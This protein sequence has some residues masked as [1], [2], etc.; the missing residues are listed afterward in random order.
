MLTPLDILTHLQTYLPALTTL[1]SDS[2]S[3]ATATVA[4][5]VVTV[6]TPSAHGLSPGTKVAFAAGQFQN[7]VTATFL[8]PDDTVRFT[9]GSDHDLTQPKFFDDPDELVLSGVGAPWDGTHKIVAVP[10]RRTFEVALPTGETTA[11]APA[12]LLVEDRPAGIT[13]L[14]TVATVPTS[15]TFT[16]DLSGVPDPPAGT[17][18]SIS[19]VTQIRVA[20]AEDAERA[21]QIYARSSASDANARPWLFLM[22]TGTDASKDRETFSDAIAGFTV[23]D[24]RKQTLLQNF[25]TI[26]ILPTADD[27]TGFTAMS[28]AHSEIFRALASAL[29]SFR[30]EDPDTSIRYVTVS[31]GHGPGTYD[32]SRYT[33]VYDWQ[34]PTVVTYANGFDRQADV[35]FR[36]I[37]Q[38]LGLNSDE[39]AQLVANIDLDDEPLP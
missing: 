33:H 39:A 3:G 26:A 16:V 20:G 35:A 11:P 34:V 24:L 30:F 7:P 36:D 15:T 9:V 17:V 31:N 37:T 8:N 10:N 5:N 4:G 25:A 19:V 14:Q 1:F 23:Q 38:T 22:M 21:A 13:G 28:Q 12:G 27:K 2:I 6:A 18:Q 32:T 29:Y